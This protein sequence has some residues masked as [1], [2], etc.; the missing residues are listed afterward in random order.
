M[1]DLGTPSRKKK[2]WA[3]EDSESDGDG[4]LAKDFGSPAKLTIAGDKQDLNGKGF[5]ESAAL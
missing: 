2:D 4:G 3:D 1:S 5:G